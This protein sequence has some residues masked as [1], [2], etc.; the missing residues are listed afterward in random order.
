MCIRDSSTGKD[1]FTGQFFTT[2]EL[3][4]NADVFFSPVDD[5]PLPTIK[6]SLI[7][8][9][10]QAKLVRTLMDPVKRHTATGEIKIDKKTLKPTEINR[11]IEVM[12]FLGF[13]FKEIPK[14]RS[15]G[16]QKVVEIKAGQKKDLNKLM[17]DI[18]VKKF[19]EKKTQRKKEKQ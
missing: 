19:N 17:H 15:K 9:S 10:P 1:S 8:V 5:R 4:T 13:P 16:E 6:E 14:F 12:K 11:G 7:S 2:P 3:P 18:G